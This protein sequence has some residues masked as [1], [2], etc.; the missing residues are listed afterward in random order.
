VLWRI[1]ERRGTAADLHDRALPEGGRVLEVLE[2]ERPALVL[3]STQ[4]LDVVDHRAVEL[5]GV[6]V[7]K[8]RSGGGSVLLLP[9]RVL[10]V[11]LTIPRDDELWS[12]DVAVSFHWLGRAWVEALRTLD[13]AAEAHEGPNRSGDWS[14]LICFAGLGAGEVLVDGRKVVG[15]SQR[16]TREAARFQ[17]LIH[18]WWD[19][20]ALLGLLDLDDERRTAGLLALADVAIGIDRPPGDLLAALLPVLP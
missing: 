15:I 7:A 8:R 6:E 20:M 1:E 17:C 10:W 14:R 11:D 4:S 16:R 13:L 18:R 2:V 12:D 19:P 9:G 5:F 3:G